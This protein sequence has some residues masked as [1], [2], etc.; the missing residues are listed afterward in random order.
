MTYRLSRLV[1]GSYDVIL[2]GVIIASLVRRGEAKNATWTAELLS[3]VH[4]TRRPAP[5][6]ELEHSFGSLEE[7]P[8][9]LG[10]SETRNAGRES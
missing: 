2:N 6:T 5:F 3:D 9:W 1:A 7:A 8:A 10:N 4:P